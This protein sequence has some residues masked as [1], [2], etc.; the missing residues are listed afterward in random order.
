MSPNSSLRSNFI[1]LIFRIDAWRQNFKLGSKIK[2]VVTER[3]KI[4]YCGKESDRILLP[5]N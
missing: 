3:S 1:G 5:Y 4:F 2:F